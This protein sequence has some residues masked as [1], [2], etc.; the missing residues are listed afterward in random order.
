MGG[1]A[2]SFWSMVSEMNILPEE[3]EARKKEIAKEIT[4][5]SAAY[6]N[7]ITEE[8]A[9]TLDDC[10]TPD[11]QCERCIMYQQAAAIVRACKVQ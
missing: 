11:C 10:V 3:Y 7:Q 9:A 8:I 4:N 6:R 5:A 2:P 1:S